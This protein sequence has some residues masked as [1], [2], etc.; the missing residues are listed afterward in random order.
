MSNIFILNCFTGKIEST[1]VETHTRGHRMID[2]IMVSL[3]TVH[4]S[5]SLDESAQSDEDIGLTTTNT[6]GVRT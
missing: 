5:G 1:G 3:T 2:R 4:L 6:R